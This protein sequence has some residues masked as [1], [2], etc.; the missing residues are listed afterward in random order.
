ME[1]NINFS[2]P[3]SASASEICSILARVMVDIA[4]NDSEGSFAWEHYEVS[5]NG[6]CIATYS[7][8]AEP[9]VEDST[10]G[11]L[12]LPDDMSDDAEALALANDSPF[13]LLNGIWT[14]NL[15]RAHSMARD[16]ESGM[17]SINE[18][19]ITFPQTA[20]TG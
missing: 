12:G 4:L 20:F 16:L 3:S 19:P 15:S 7:V 13:G 8:L 17:V 10:H 1:I 6:E 11:W 2:V 18:Y 14:Q 9:D 5:H